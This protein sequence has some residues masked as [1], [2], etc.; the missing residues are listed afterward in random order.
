MRT[1]DEIR[2]DFEGLE[3]SS[4]PM[5]AY[6]TLMNELQRDYYTFRIDPSEAFL[7]RPEVV[8]YNQICASRIFE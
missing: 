4:D 2:K 7:N 1:L 8:L 5:L 6:V 3:I